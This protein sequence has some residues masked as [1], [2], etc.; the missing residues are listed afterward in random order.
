FYNFG[1]PGTKTFYRTIKCLYMNARSIVECRSTDIT[2]SEVISELNNINPTKSSGPDNIPGI[3][4]KNTA[5]AITPSLCRVFNTSLGH[6]AMIWKRANI[7]PVFKGDEQFLAKN[8]RPIS[9]LCIVSK[10]LER[11]DGQEV[12]AIHLDLSKAFDRVP[13]RLLLDKLKCY[14]IDGQLLEW[15]DSY[16]SDRFRHVVLDGAFSDWLPVTSGVPQGSILGPL[17]FVIYVIDM[18]NYL[19]SKS[20]LA[21]FADDSKLYRPITSINSRH[22]LQADLHGLNK[23][24]K[25]HKIIACHLI[26]QNAK[27]LEC[28]GSGHHQIPLT[29]IS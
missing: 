28:Q 20:N 23:W 13:H 29:I 9:L 5:E 22:E 27:F 24:S 14:G 18:P 16:L 26:L 12:D 15:F 1:G 10:I 11:S 4:L 3:L 7:L 17:L 19:T 25:D 6:V 21:L 2:V 8:Y